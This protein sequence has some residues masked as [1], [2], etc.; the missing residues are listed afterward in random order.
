MYMCVHIE[1]RLLMVLWCVVI[2]C[3]SNYYR[4]NHSNH[5]LWCSFFHFFHCHSFFLLLMASVSAENWWWYLL[6]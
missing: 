2:L 5:W 1:S 4:G 6:Q 3:I